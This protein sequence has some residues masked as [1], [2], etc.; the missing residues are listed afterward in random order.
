MKHLA[1]RSLLLAGLICLTL[2]FLLV[3]CDKGGNTADTTVA[4]VT[5][6]TLTDAPTEA[7]TT[8]PETEAPKGGCGSV[9]GFSAAAILCAVAA[10]MA[11]K[12]D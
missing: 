5:T 1:R 6:N 7:P 10:A 2:C 9:I 3:A 11:M 8:P 4:D 12:K